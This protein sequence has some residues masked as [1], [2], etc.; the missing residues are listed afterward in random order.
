MYSNLLFILILSLSSISSFSNAKSR[1]LKGNYRWFTPTRNNQGC[2]K[3]KINVNRYPIVQPDFK[4]HDTYFGK[5]IR[6]YYRELENTTTRKSRKFIKSLNHLTEKTL[7]KSNLRKKVQKT[8]TK[9]LDYEKFGMYSKHGDYYYF[10]HNTG[11]QEQDV[12]KRVKKLG[13]TPETFLDVNELSKDGSVGLDTVE[14]SKDGSVMAYSLIINGSDW[15]TIKFK[16]ANGKDLPDVLTNVKFSGM[17]FAFGAKGFIYGS[18]PERKEI[19]EDYVLY[20]HKMG[21]QQSKDFVLIDDNKSKDSTIEADI[22]EDERYLFVYY[23]ESADDYNRVGYYDLSKL[24]GKEFTKKIYPTPIFDKYEAEYSIFGNDKD[25]IYVFTNK[26]AP[27]GKIFKLNLKDISKGEKKWNVIVKEES[28]ST[29][30]IVSMIGSK[31]FIVNR[32]KDVVSHL[33]VH[34]KETGKLIRELTLP[35]GVVKALSSRNDTNEFFIGFTNQATPNTIYKGNLD[36]LK[37]KKV[38]EF[39]KVIQNVPKGFKGDDLEV[40]QIFYKSTDGAKVPMFMLHKKG[41]KLNGKNPVILEG[42]GGFGEVN[43]P[44]FST[45]RYLFVRKFSGIWCIANI[46]GGGEYGD[47]WHKA[48]MRHNKQHTFDDIIHAAKYLIKHRYTNPSKLS[49]YGTS[50]GGLVVTVASQQRPDL[51]GA[52]IS[53]SALY[54]MLRYTNFTI[55]RAWIPEFGDPSIKEDFKYLLTYSPLH[56]IRRP[57]RFGQ[58]PSTFMSSDLDDDRVPVG[59]TLKYAATLY[60]FFKSKLRYQKNPVI[61]QIDK[62]TG[63]GDGMGLSKIINEIS[64]EYAFLHLALNLKWKHD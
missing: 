54:D 1:R 16:K 25:V 17:Q 62:G 40:T 2:P 21:T 43:A 55:G 28:D 44:Y 5:R 6:D 15:T 57:K 63:H 14:F 10:F 51:F 61:V 47:K 32:L 20:Y 60:N 24:N 42:Y 33:Y 27:N 56:N 41:L 64:D 58:W 29:I 52:V 39:K 59:H 48:G 45:S 3:V 23:F 18:Y 53:K 19:D 26:G 38:F 31:Y 37:L 4:T 11:L 9:Y 35:K 7:K 30:D 36:D 12:L 50:N 46:R 8:L 22:S 13:D 34:E 49:I